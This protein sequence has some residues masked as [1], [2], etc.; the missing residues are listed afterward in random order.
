MYPS[1]AAWWA[2]YHQS[3]AISA[4]TD[5]SSRASPENTDL[6]AQAAEYNAM[7]S[8]GTVALGADSRKPTTDGVAGA[9]DLDYWQLLPSATGA[10]GRLKIDAID[11]DLPIYHGTDDD[12]LEKGVGHLEGTALPVGGAD[13]HS[14][15]TAHRGLASATLFD[16]LDKV[17][18]GDRFSVHVL[19]ET[20]TYEVH[21]TQVVEPSDTETLF[22]SPDED[23]MTLVTCTPLG[24]NTHRILVT[25]ERITPTPV[26]DVEAA[27]RKPEVPRFPWWALI[28]SGGVLGAGAFIWRSG[29]SRPAP[30]GA[31]AAAA[32]EPADA[33]RREG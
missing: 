28:I 25:G 30:A 9:T 22:P 7:L 10:M 20:L 33:D 21:S 2:Q 23:L 1:T 31:A 5:Q 24:I 18:V 17:D 16:N 29:Y 19:G 4:Y 27:N 12:V 3:Q 6:L 11:V 15:L 26:E 32:P 14:V 8:A 13:T